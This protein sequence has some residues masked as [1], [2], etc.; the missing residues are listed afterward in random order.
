M[1][2]T[3]VKTITKNTLKKYWMIYLLTLLIAAVI[4]YFCRTTD[5]DAL[6][7]ILTPTA[8]WASTLSGISFEYLSH[9]GY[10]NHYHKFLFAPACSGIRFMLL[11]FLMCIFSFLYQI[12]DIRKGYLWFVFSIV[13]AYVSTIFVNGVRIIASIYVPIR[14]ED[15]ALMDEWLNQDRLHTIIGTTVYFSSL[16]IIYLLA[17]FICKRMFMQVTHHNTNQ[18]EDNTLEDFRKLR[19]IIAPLFWYLS[20]VL[21]LPLVKRFYLNDWS[22][23]GQ[24]TTLIMCTCSSVM[25]IILMRHLIRIHRQ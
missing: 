13:F 18:S 15:W 20:M 5:S 8:R 16:F 12:E 9:M 17:A 2:F 4:K 25:F 19:A 7:W 6:K 23:F 10:V 14:L 1:K 21:V 22:G 3:Q 11:T 24:Y